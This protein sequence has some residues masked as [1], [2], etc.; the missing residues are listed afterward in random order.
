MPVAVRLRD[1]GV[2]PPVALDLAP[3]RR[4]IPAEDAGDPRSRRLCLQQPGNRAP[5]IKR[6]VREGTSYGRLLICFRKLCGGAFQNRNCPL[7]A[8]LRRTDFMLLAGRTIRFTV[9]LKNYNKCS[10][11]VMAKITSLL[12]A[13]PYHARSPSSSISARTPF[14]G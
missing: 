4:A 5:F 14:Y 10:G 2:V 13:I 3:D 12:R 1:F 6:Q 8:G 7:P 9:L 11:P